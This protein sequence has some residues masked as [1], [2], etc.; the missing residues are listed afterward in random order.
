MEQAKTRSGL[1]V[2]MGL[3]EK[4]CATGRKYKADFKANV[5]IVFDAHLPKWNYRVLPQ[6][7]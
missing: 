5:K 6:T 1:R 2:T 7:E 3:L 4:V